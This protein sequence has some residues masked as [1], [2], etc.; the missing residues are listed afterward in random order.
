MHGVQATYIKY[1]LAGDQHLGHTK[2]GL[3]QDKPEIAL[4]PPYFDGSQD[5]VCTAVSECFSNIFPHKIRI[6]EMW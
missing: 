5:L 6:G 3:S 4:F 1:D 2:C